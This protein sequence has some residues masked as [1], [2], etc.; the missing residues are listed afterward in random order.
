MSRRLCSFAPRIASHV[1]PGVAA[2]LRNGDLA[3]PGEVL[4]RDGVLR[5]D[6]PFHGSLEH[7]LAA[8]LACSGTDVDDMVGNADRLL[9]VLDD[10]NRV[11]EVAKPHERVDQPAVVP[12]VETDRR[13]VEDVEHPHQTAADLT[14]EPD[15]L[16]LTAGERAR[17][18]T[19]REVVE[20]DIEQE[21]HAGIHFFHDPLGDHPVSF[22]QLE[23]RQRLGRLTDAQVAELVDVAPIDGDGE[24]RGAQSCP[25]TCRARDLAH[26]A[27]D[28]LAGPVALG[29]GV[30]AAQERDDAL[31]GRLERALTAVAVLVLHLDGARLGSVQDDGLLRLRQLGPRRVHVDAV[32]LRDRTDQ[33]RE[34]LRCASRPTARSRLRSTRGRDWGRRARG[35]L[36]RS[37]RGRRRSHMRHKAN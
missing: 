13:L 17:R 3:L 31:V 14:G 15:A 5:S 12:L 28:L 37:C 19:Q 36:R 23:R 24:R 29:V 35:R 8:V 21:A 22:A 7:D 10:E 26:V 1:S 16:S 11:A 33:S 25:A 27:L 18:P 20:P 30:P 4:T 34:V 6:E 32:L 9:V 2:L